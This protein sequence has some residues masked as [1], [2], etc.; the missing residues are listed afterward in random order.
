[1]ANLKVPYK[2]QWDD[3]ARGTINDCGPTSVAMI[4]NHYGL[5]VTTDEVFSRTGAG[6]GVISVQQLQQAI[7]SYGH[8]SKYIKGSSPTELKKLIDNGIPVIALVHYGDLSSRQD[9]N[10]T[11]G[12]FLVVTG[13][14]RD[15][16]YVNDPDFWGE[17]RKDGVHNYLKGEFEQAWV[18]A[19]LDKNPPNALLYIEPI[20]STTS[21]DKNTAL[22]LL[23]KYKQE[24]DHGN[25]EGAMR[26]LL[27]ASE[28]A[29]KLEAVESQL[30]VCKNEL[31]EVDETIKKKVESAVESANEQND[32]KWQIEV[33]SAKWIEFNKAKWPVHVIT[34][35][36]KFFNTYKDKGGE[37]NG[38]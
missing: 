1:M 25:L 38:S 19:S 16:Y 11:D 4:L 22:D 34:A 8:S 36:T 7:S 12:H 28:S 30:V 33:E 27:G 26:A 3:D 24:A 31:H 23:E 21:E 5:N 9:K 15:G 37:T 13:Y 35:F 32:A 6:S 10:Y 17:F 29:K 2:S 18:N 20:E 14:H